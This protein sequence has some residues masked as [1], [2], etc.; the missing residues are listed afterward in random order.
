[1]SLP[2]NIRKLESP[3]KCEACLYNDKDSTAN[4][5]VCTEADSFGSEWQPIC[6]PCLD[7]HKSELHPDG[8]LGDCEWCRSV[9]VMVKPT[10]DYEEGSFGPVYDVCKQCRINQA[11]RAQEEFD[12]LEK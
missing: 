9:D 12:S 4:L 10:R 6:Q 8:T 5:E 7:K 11:K 3:E 2:G 1:M